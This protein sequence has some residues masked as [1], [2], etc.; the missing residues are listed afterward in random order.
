G[1][2]VFKDLHEFT[3][4]R[5]RLAELKS[6]DGPA[7]APESEGG[8]GMQFPAAR[9]LGDYQLH[10]IKTRG[11]AGAAELRKWLRDNGHAEP[12]EDALRWYAQRQ[13][14]WL[15]AR[16]NSARGLPDAADLKPLRLSFATPRPVFPLKL[17]DGRGAFDAEIWVI[18]REKLDPAK[19]RPFGFAAPEQD[20]DYYLQENRE[21]GFTRLPESV[22][23]L[24]R[25][26]EELKGLRLGTIWCWRL[27]ARNLEAR[28]GQDVG[29]WLDDLQFALERDSTAKPEREARPTPEEKPGEKPGDR[30]DDKGADQGEKA[31]GGK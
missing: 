3:T 8:Q 27:S 6:E 12:A 2:T 5:P 20:D 10:V 1:L 18:T 31:P 13:W 9:N 17:C 23:E 21:T 22:Q 14:C 25:D 11:E 28:N 16:L 29:S 26:S 30:P 15:V 19:L 24:C 7:I 4:V